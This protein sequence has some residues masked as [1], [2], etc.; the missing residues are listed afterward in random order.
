M[1]PPKRKVASSLA[2]LASKRA[3]LREELRVIEETYA[4]QEKIDAEVKK[5]ES[6]EELVAK[7]KEIIR[8]LESTLP[9][10]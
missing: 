1:S 8:E 9:D 2:D 4:I 7:S 6:Y 5:L 10:Q 3:K